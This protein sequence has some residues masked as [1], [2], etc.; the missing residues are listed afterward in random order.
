VAAKLKP[1]LLLVVLLSAAFLAFVVGIGL[2]RASNES[3]Q[4][5]V[6]SEARETAE[7]G[8]GEEMPAGFNLESTPA[9]A[10]A[11]LASMAL[12]VVA[13]G[14]GG[15]PAAPL[16]IPVFCL[17]FAA[18]DGLELVH[19]LSESRPLLAGAATTVLSLHVAAAFVAALLTRTNPVTEDQ[20]TAQA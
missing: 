20:A 17:A 19:Q 18:A 5:T 13:T 9:R 15:H 10:L 1:R 4:G 12:V 6:H 7:T 16:A 14:A 2:E 11:I 3:A 8:H